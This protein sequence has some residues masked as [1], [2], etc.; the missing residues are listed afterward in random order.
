MY[1]SV[2]INMSCTIVFVYKSF[3]KALFQ[4]ALSKLYF[5]LKEENSL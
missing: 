1:V 2:V 5:M 3:K 4:V